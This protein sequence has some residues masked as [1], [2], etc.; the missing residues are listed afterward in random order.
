MDSGSDSSVVGGGT[1]KWCVNDM[2]K[3]DYGSNS[4]TAATTA[5]ATATNDRKTYIDQS[6][7]CA[8]WIDVNGTSHWVAEG[9]GNED[10]NSI[11]VGDGT[12]N[13]NENAMYQGP[14]E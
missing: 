8:F 3:D 4:S 1:L 5:A 6:S 2:L 11:V 9:D 10:G 13:W 12:L 7:G 14:F